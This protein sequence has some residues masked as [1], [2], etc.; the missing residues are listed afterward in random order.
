MRAARVHRLVVGCVAVCALAW[1]APAQ[2]AP[3][4]L[5][6]GFG[7]DGK[8]TTDF[9]GQPDYAKAVVLQSDGKIVAVGD[10]WSEEPAVPFFA[11]DFALARYKRDGTLDATFGGDGTVT[12]DVLGGC[13]ADPF[14]FCGFDTA[15]AAA[16]QADGKVVVAG[17]TTIRGFAP[18]GA[19]VNT[20]VALARYNAD[21]TLDTTFS[22][23]GR[24][25]TDVLGSPD[26]WETSRDGA[27]SVAIQPDGKIIAAG[28]TQSES[29][30]GL[31]L[32]RY[33]P[34]GTR[35]SS[36]GDHGIVV[37][38]DQAFLTGMA[39]Q[40]DRRI[41]V[42]ARTPT[43]FVLARYTPAG[44]PDD[45]F[46]ADGVVQT[47]STT[48]VTIQP[49]GRIVVA[50]TWSSQDGT[51]FGL[52]RYNADGTPDAGFGDDGEVRTDFLDA[53]AANA[54]AIQSDGGIVAAGAATTRT[55]REGGFALARYTA[56]GTL[57]TRGGDDGRTI[58]DFP[59]PTRRTPAPPATRGLPPTRS[60]SSPTAGS[61]SRATPASSRAPAS[62][63]T[64]RSRGT[65][66]P[67][68]GGLMRPGTERSTRAST[69]RLSI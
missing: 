7:G 16:L 23:D 6:S 53:D 44:A 1:A 64:S 63:R 15:E 65:T 25:T 62:P 59:N 56:D 47:D 17:R 5:D 38:G 29:V 39:L 52:A 45:T 10:A 33:N 55:T 41:V 3:N 69:A 68:H 34:D 20:D 58:T 61:S 37:Y 35:D 11:K 46:G 43:G 14:E 31:L 24:V 27:K 9:A 26:P 32:V 30:S 40:A 57:D 28:Y 22:G 51:D 19:P 60:P 48:A 42:T 12:T 18:E 49:D 8:V 2:A 50:G 54:V 21:G 67:G 36:F 13:T 4:G 66:P